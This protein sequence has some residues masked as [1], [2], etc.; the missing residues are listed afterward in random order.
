M[1]NQLTKFA[2]SISIGYED[3]KGYAECRKC[4]GLGYIRVTHGP[5]K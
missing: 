2:F 1:V 4:S 3:V 5:W